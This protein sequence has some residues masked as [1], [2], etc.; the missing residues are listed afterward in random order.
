MGPRRRRRRHRRHHRPRA[1]RSSAISS[2]VDLPK[3]GAHVGAVGNPSAAWSRVKAVSDIY[4]PVSGE[5]IEINAA[6]A[7]APEKVNE[8]PARRRLADE[9]AS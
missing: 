6:L 3:V 7:D 5:V 2:I 4:S 1:G 9:D 8:R